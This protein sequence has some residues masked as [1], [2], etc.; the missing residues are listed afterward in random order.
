MI[1]KVIHYIWLGGAPLSPLIE[2]CIESWKKQCP[3]YEIKRWDES[4][5][6][7]GKY[8]FAKEAYDAKNWAFA[9]D[10]FRYDVLYNNGGIYLDTDVELLKPLDEFLKYNF[11]AG[12]ED[13]ETIGQSWEAKSTRKLPKICWKSTKTPSLHK[14]IATRRQFVC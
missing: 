2:K 11:F 4:N 12:F 10:V 3:D 13:D 7:I 8:K 9:S 14:K 6:D 1:P 5:L